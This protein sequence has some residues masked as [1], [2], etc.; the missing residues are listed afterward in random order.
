MSQ[1]IEDTPNLRLGFGV[2]CSAGWSGCAF[3]GSWRPS[4]GLVVAGGVEGEVAEELTGG[5]VDDADVQVLDQEKDAGSGVGPSD[6][7]VVKTAVIAQ[8]DGA[9]VVDAVGPDA[10]VGVSVAVTRAGL[11]PGG[12]AGGRSGVARQ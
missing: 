6:A 12:V 1:D 11:G 10:L 3:R 8:G 9:G 4:G 5:G 7:D 2:S